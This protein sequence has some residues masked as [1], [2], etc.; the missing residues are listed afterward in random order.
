MSSQPTDSL[1]HQPRHPIGVVFRRTG[2]K[3]DVLRAWEKRYSAVSPARSSGNRRVYSD[4]DIE[5][6]LFLRQAIEGGRRISQVAQLNHAELEEL[7]VA[8]RSA[9]PHLR[10]RQEV[11]QKANAEQHLAACLWAVQELEAGELAILLEPAAVDLSQPQLMEGVLV[12]LMEEVGEQ[13]DQGSLR[14][15]HEHMACAVTCSFL[16]G[17]PAGCEVPEGAPQL[18]VATPVRQ[19]HEVGARMVAAT[20]ASLGWCVTYLGTSLSAEEIAAAAQQKGAR[21]VD[22][23]IVYPP[24]DPQLP[25]ELGKLRRHL[26]D[27]ISLLV[28]GRSAW[29]YREVVQEIGARHLQGVTQLGEELQNLRGH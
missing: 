21:A 13:W 14:V 19:F 2:L 27:P 24:D 5:K 22:L 28:G 6:L 9:T 3:P 15:A 20:A 16:S 12:P 1:Y 29:S 18:V 10:T 8:D 4:A 17:L 26:E 11:V 25:E 23:S 7:V